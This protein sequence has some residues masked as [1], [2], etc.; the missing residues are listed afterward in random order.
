[1]TPGRYRTAA[2]SEVTVSGKYGGI[3][4]FDFDWFEEGA[5]VEAAPYILDDCLCWA[6]D[7]HPDDE[8][9]A[10]LRRVEE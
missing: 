7:C 2:G 8:G 3:Y 6:C 9:C 10:E 5:C 1:M 4:D